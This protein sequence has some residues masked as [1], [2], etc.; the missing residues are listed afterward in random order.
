MTWDAGLL[1]A[2]GWGTPWLGSLLPVSREWGQ[3]SLHAFRALTL[4]TVEVTWAAASSSSCLD[5]P[6]KAPWTWAR[7][8]PSSLKLLLSGYSVETEKEREKYSHSWECAQFSV[9]CPL[10]Q[11]TQ[12][13]PS[14]LMVELQINVS[15]DGFVPGIIHTFKEKSG[16]SRDPPVPGTLRKMTKQITILHFTDHLNKMKT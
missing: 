12:K 6:A 15:R 13:A 11:I 4:L 1:C 16:H 14:G 3:S 2:C 10:L 9:L 8:S 5:F 7:A